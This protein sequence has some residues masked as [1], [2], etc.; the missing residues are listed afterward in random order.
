MIITRN[1]YR[2]SIK[3]LFQ[4]TEKFNLYHIFY[5]VVNHLLQ[6]SKL[7]VLHYLMNYLD[8][9]RC[10]ITKKISMKFLYVNRQF[11]NLNIIANNYR[12]C[13]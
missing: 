4:V 2:I 1:S 10:C 11:S 12:N 7:L 9:E 13:N 8:I 5:L 6:V 3:S